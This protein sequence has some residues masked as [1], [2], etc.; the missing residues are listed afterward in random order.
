MNIKRPGDIVARY[1]GKEFVVLIPETDATGT[2][3]L[4][5]QIRKTIEEL[6]I[7]L[8]FVSVADVVTISLGVA[9]LHPSD[10][11]TF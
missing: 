9:T 6:K 10:E 7:P 8:G 2:M 4:A 11:K 3:K 1:A 5:E